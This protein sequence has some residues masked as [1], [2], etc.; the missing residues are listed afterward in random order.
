MLCVVFAEDVVCGGMFLLWIFAQ[1]ATFRST[2]NQPDLFDQNLVSFQQMMFMQKS[3]HMQH[4]RIAF[5]TGR[6]ILLGGVC[7]RGWKDDFM[8]PYLQFTNKHQP[9]SSHCLHCAITPEIHTCNALQ[10]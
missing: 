9:W 2:R 5:S 6:P 8:H 3:V 1:A 7:M 10:H 4:D